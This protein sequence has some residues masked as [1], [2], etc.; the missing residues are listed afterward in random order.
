MNVRHAGLFFFILL[1]ALSGCSHSLSQKQ[2]SEMESLYTTCLT[3]HS[4]KEM[5]RGPVLDGLDAFYIEMQLGKFK[6]KVRGDNAENRQEYLM[7]SA[8]DL[9]NKDEIRQMSL[10]IASLE[11]KPYIKTVEGNIAAGKTLY[12]KQC[13]SCHGQK[14]EGRK[15]LKT[16]SLAVLEDWYLMLQLKQF[17]LGQRGY[18]VDDVAGKRMQDIVKEIT[19]DDLN[20]VVAYIGET[21]GKQIE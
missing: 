7:G 11:I 16:G 5:Q 13:M 19:I 8:M 10:Y 1:L 3:C 15:L 14:A 17:K 4:N 18:H 6:A 20:D 2:Q 12:E 9:M 21:F